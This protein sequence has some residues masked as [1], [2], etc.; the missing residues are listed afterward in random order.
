MPVFEIIYTD[1]FLD[2]AVDL[3]ELE[4]KEEEIF[5]AIELIL[6]VPVLGSRNLPSSIIK[7]FGNTVRKLVVSP[8]LIIYEIDDQQKRIMVLGLI[9]ERMA[10]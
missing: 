7:R 10:R 9:P 1:S 3:V 4:S 2:D 5:N 6:H 8:F